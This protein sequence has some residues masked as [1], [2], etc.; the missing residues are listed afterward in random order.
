[1][2]MNVRVIMLIFAAD[3]NRSTEQGSQAAGT[4]QVVVC[5]SP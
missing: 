4:E 1:M 3:K 5:Q 2:G